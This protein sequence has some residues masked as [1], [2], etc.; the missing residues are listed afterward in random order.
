M[1]G[2][3]VEKLT[4][5]GI[6]QIRDIQGAIVMYYG[7]LDL[8]SDDIAMLFGLNRSDSR[9][10]DLK[11][12]A[13]KKVKEKGLPVWSVQRVPTETAFEAWNLD[14]NALEVRAEKLRKMK[15]K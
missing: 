3:D 13:M 15:G 4:P 1:K 8:S 6:P 11:R 14:I 10:T 2:V 9:I 7:L 5:R 12:M